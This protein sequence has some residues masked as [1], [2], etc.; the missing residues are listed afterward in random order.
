VKK[1][2]RMLEKDRLRKRDGAKKLRKRGLKEKMERAK[3]K[4]LRKRD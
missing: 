2:D 3:K 4:I 1:A